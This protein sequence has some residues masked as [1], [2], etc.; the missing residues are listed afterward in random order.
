VIRIEFD[1]PEPEKP[2][3]AAAT[4]PGEAEA[5]LGASDEDAIAAV[6]AALADL[7][8]AAVPSRAAAAPRVVKRQARGSARRK[9]AMRRGVPLREATLLAFGGILAMARSTVR[10]VASD[11]E[12]AVHDYRKSIRRA[13]AIIALL[14]P[15]LGRRAAAGIAAEL[16]RAFGDTSALRDGHV[17]AATLETVE[18]HDPAR[19]S[20][21][22]ALAREGSGDDARAAGVLAAGVD[23]LRPLP[24][25]LRV[26]LPPAFSMDDLARGL[27]RS[28]RRV[29]RTL[30][31]AGTTGL[32]DDFHE[33]RKRAKELRYQVE[34]L[35]STGSAELKRREKTLAT[36]A[37]ELGRVTDLIVLD[38]ALADRQR[39]GTLPE[40]PALSEA[41]G[42][43]IVGRSLELIARGE[44]LFAE[45]PADFA[46]KILAE[47]G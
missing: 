33:W 22:H 4:A 38:K 44:A 11:P 29:Q 39:V 42:A 34:M 46:R 15:A 24:D 32:P 16:R 5:L 1:E 40:A 36:L 18:A 28:W 14:R 21:L 17:L 35:A 27:A 13:R 25:V 26:T 6:E 9:L 2:A 41:I 31:E 12:A 3:D 7:L 8:A 43:A 37:E 30:G 10:R 19:P 20:I 47:R 23:I 45:A